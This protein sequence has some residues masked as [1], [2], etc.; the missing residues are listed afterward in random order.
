MNLRTGIML[1]GCLGLQVTGWAQKDSAAAVHSF[2]VQQCVEYGLKNNLQV[3]N[4]LLD[5]Q[6]QEQTNK[7]ITAMAYPQI[8]GSLGTTHF[9]NVAVQSFPNFIAAATY[10]VLALEGVKDG[11]GNTIV[12]PSDFGFVQAAFGT[13]WNASAGITLSQILFD[14]QV[15]VGLQARQT[16]MDFQRKA[17]DVTNEAIKVNIYKIYYQLVA[18]KIQTDQIDA[19]IS[20]LEKLQH[21]ANE[22]FKNGFAEKLDVDKVVVQLA[23]LQTERTNLQKVIDNGYLG[24]KYLIGMPIKDSLVLTDGITDEKIKE[25]LLNEG[26]Y[27]YKDRNDFQY[28]Q[29]AKR[30]NEYNIKRYQL[31]KLP[32]ANLNASYSKIAQ[33]NS[34]SFFGKG[35]WFASSFVGL[36]INVP[37]FAGLAKNASIQKSRLELK[38][39]ENQLD[40]LKNS[41]DNDVAAATNNFKNAIL[42]LDFQKQ[43]MALAEKVYDQSKKKYEIGTGSNTEINNAQTDLR[44]AQNNY[45]NAL[46]NAIIA[47]VDYL[48]AIGKL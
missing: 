23:N 11:N 39:T 22:L 4:A 46:Y 9:P 44:I 15:F 43:N 35:D 13:K 47:R 14:G 40:N 25:G 21:D 29:L 20:R 30:L 17:V 28:L 6:I 19:N 10:G 48:K 1:V 37:I 41:I 27:D 2:T 3:K 31:T 32:S 45:V 12:P 36:S 18:S 33:R 42:T 26:V 16:S 5:V 38:Q 24:L 8:N 34:F 7:N